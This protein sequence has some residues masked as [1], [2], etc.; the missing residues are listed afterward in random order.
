LVNRVP[1]NRDTLLTA[2]LSRTK[3]RVH[4]PVSLRDP[5][6]VVLC[7]SFFTTKA[8]NEKDVESQID[9]HIAPREH[10]SGQLEDASEERV[11]CAW[12]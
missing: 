8:A 4:R 12:H 11:A 2:E 6:E 5:A 10:T 7:D 1:D 3:R 9:V